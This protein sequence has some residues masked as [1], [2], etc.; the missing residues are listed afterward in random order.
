MMV[1]RQETGWMMFFLIVFS[2]AL[3][4]ADFIA[5]ITMR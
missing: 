1:D 2:S 3:V 4:M 5:T